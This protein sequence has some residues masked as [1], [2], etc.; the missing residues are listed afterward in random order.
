[1]NPI[2]KKVRH[3][4]QQKIEETRDRLGDGFTVYMGNSDKTAMNTA[5]ETG[6]I[7][8]LEFIFNLE[9]D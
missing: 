7:E 9:G 5:K 1:M 6:R 8:G 3:R 4:I 2:T